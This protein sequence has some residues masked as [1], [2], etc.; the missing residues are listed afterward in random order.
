MLIRP[1]FW[2]Y[3]S[4]SSSIFPILNEFSERPPVHKPTFLI[5]VAIFRL[6]NATEVDFSGNIGHFQRI[7]PE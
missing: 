7:R 2:G 5:F 3:L 4:I 1:N 6:I